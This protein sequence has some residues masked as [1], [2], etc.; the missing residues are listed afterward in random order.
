[1]RDLHSR[2]AHDLKPQFHIPAMPVIVY[3]QA[4]SQVPTPAGYGLSGIFRK[5]AESNVARTHPTGHA[6]GKKLHPVIQLAACLDTN[7]ERCRRRL[8]VSGAGLILALHLQLIELQ[9]LLHNWL[10]R[11]FQLCVC[12]EK[13]CLRFA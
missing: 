8:P 13:N 12:P 2:T 9:K 3:R 6:Q 1:V 7:A 10:V 11:F 4:I 5:V